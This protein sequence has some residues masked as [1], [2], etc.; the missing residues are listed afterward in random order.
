MKNINELLKENDKKYLVQAILTD[1]DIETV[2]DSIRT[3]D[4]MHIV[5]FVMKKHKSS[6]KYRY[7]AMNISNQEILINTTEN[8]YAW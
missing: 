8:K 7:I 5:E 6:R 3:N 2:I 1:G 4:Y